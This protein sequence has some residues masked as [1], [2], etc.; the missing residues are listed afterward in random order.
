MDGGGIGGHST[1]GCEPN[2]GVPL[3]CEEVGVCGGFLEQNLAFVVDD[4]QQAEVVGAGQ[5][6]LGGDQIV[7]VGH[8]FGD[9]LRGAGQVFV[10]EDMATEGAVFLEEGRAEI[11]AIEV[12][13]REDGEVGEAV[14]HH[15]PGEAAG[16]KGVVHRQAHQVV[17]GDGETG[18]GGGAGNEEHA[19]RV[20][21]FE[22]SLGFGAGFGSDHHLD[23]LG[24][25]LLQL[26][27]GD[28]GIGGGV[29]DEQLEGRHAGGVGDFCEGASHATRHC[30]HLVGTNPTVV[31]VHFFGMSL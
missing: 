25:E 11:F 19:M 18:G 7:D 13:A 10:E 26:G 1:V 17:V 28:V 6:N 3:R 15:L 2:G 20:G 12:G 5:G 31:G 21:E 24:V 23:A 22:E 9:E 4:H 16:L 29:F 8:D 14:V 27:Q 30:S